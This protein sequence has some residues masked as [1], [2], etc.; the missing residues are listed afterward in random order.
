[1]VPLV[2]SSTILHNPHSGPKKP[3]LVGAGEPSGDSETDDLAKLNLFFITHCS[4]C[5]EERFHL[6]PLLETNI[7]L[8]F[9]S[10]YLTQH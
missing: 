5:E 1:M 3:L 6:A 4:A 8:P 7:L 9:F 10:R 2:L